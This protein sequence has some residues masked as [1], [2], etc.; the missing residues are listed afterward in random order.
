MTTG[1]GTGDG[2][3]WVAQPEPEPAPYAGDP[4]AAPASWG[5]TLSPRGDAI[6][7]VSDRGGEPQLWTSSVDGAHP[8]EVPTGPEPVEEV[9]WSPD[10]EWLA[11]LIAPG[12][13][14]RTEIWV[15]RPDGTDLHQIGGFGGTNGFFGHW[16]HDGAWLTVAE[17]DAAGRSAAHLIDPSTGWRVTVGEADLRAAIDVSRDGTTALVRCGLRSARWLEVVDVESGAAHRLFPADGDGSTDLGHLS[18]DGGSVY[19]RTDVGRRL[20]ALVAVPVGTDGHPRVLAQRDDAELE[21]FT[22]S[23]DGGTAA[24]LWNVFGGRSEVS[25]LDLRTGEERSLTDLPGDVVGDLDLS[26]DGVTL[27]LTA[28]SPSLPPTIWVIE[29]ASGAAKPVTYPPPLPVAPIVPELHRFIAHD[30]LE[31]TGWLYPGAGTSGAGPM[32]LHFHGGP[33]AQERPVWNPLFREVVSRGISVFAP[34]VRGSSGFGRAFVNADN[35]EKR[36]AGIEDVRTAARYVID[37]GLAD[38]ARLGVFGRSYGGYLT[39]VAL[40]QFPELFAVGVDTCGM[41]DLQTFYERTEPWVAAA[42]TSKYGHPDHDRELLAEL[43]P[44]HRI[45]R[46]V[47]PL[48]VAHGANDTNVPLYEAEQVVAALEARNHPVQYLLFDDE[49]HEVLRKPNRVVYVKAVGSFLAAHLAS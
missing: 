45:D 12:G 37:A 6:A 36:H 15:V 28:E 48:L 24:L 19:V 30:G 22:L 32:V 39:L 18:A 10:G 41:A 31:L 5:A 40:T 26:A 23:E 9:R 20:P 47:A 8:V 25:V 2:A 35:L 38:P 33:E 16:S 46:L 3:N 27:A 42:A 4:A 1:L 11:V 29:V 17:A 49:G 44:I 14:D 43:S 7:F 34:N 21:Y 13:S